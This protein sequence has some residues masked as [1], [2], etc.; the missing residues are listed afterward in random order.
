MRLAA[1]PRCHSYPRLGTSYPA[2]DL[3]QIRREPMLALLA[4]DE[5]TG[6]EGE[7]VSRLAILSR[8]EVGQGHPFALTGLAIIQRGDGVSDQQTL[9]LIDLADDDRIA[10]TIAAWIFLCEVPDPV[11]FP[12]RVGEQLRTGAR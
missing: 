8:V 5:E 4:V 3:R 12:V 2:G 7:D 10:W 1:Q 9:I 11:E 6:Q